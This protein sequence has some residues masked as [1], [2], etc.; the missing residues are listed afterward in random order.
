MQ[1]HWM[2]STG[3]LSWAMSAAFTA[4]TGIA[5]SSLGGCGFQERAHE[6]DL[7][8]VAQYRESLRS[9][10]RA[11][12]R[13]AFA[14]AETFEKTGPT[15]YQDIG[16][17]HSISD[18]LEAAYRDEFSDQGKLP[19]L[20]SNANAFYAHNA[21]RLAAVKMDERA[22]SIEQPFLDGMIRNGVYFLCPFFI[23]LGIYFAFRSRKKD[24]ESRKMNPLGLALLGGFM[25]I[26]MAGWPGMTLGALSA[27]S[28][29]PRLYKHEPLPP[30]QPLSAEFCSQNFPR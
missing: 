29:A 15:A 6:P 23:P 9:D 16:H 8:R 13:Q 22:R 10:P 14:D 19:T 18:S 21:V 1:T 2:A 4:V 11:T 20:E 30:Q 27:K 24:E 7:K 26:A 25:G 12:C 5:A 3:G 17:L 28:V